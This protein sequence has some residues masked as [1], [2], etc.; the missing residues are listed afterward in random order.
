MFV[1]L[2]FRVA[3]L[4]F[5]SSLSGIDRAAPRVELLLE[6]GGVSSILLFFVSCSWLLVPVMLTCCCLMHLRRGFLRVG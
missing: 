6:S 4:S 5:L 1:C 2:V 3:V